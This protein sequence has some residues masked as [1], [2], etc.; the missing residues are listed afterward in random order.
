MFSLFSHFSVRAYRA[1]ITDFICCE[2]YGAGHVAVCECPCVNH[3]SY[4]D[5]QP[6]IQ[7]FEENL[8]GLWLKRIPW[9]WDRRSVV[10]PPEARHP[11]LSF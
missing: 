4:C 11:A 9:R 10:V 5:F 6:F 1:R 3:W 7:L 2:N 8:L